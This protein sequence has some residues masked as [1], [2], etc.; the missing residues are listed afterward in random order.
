M[1][2]NRDFSNWVGRNIHI[3]PMNK[4]IIAVRVR[5]HEEIIAKL[6]SENKALREVALDLYKS[7]DGAIKE[8]TY[9]LAEKLFDDALLADTQEEGFCP[10]CD[11]GVGPCIG[12]HKS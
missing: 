1:K 4:A 3:D 11:A 7:R 2:P 8:S 5:G 12:P 10:A 6:E 9:I